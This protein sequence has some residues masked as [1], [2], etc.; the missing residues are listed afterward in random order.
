M[1]E[2]IFLYS[3]RSVFVLTLLYVPYLL[4]LRK[5]SFFRLNRVVL[6][7]ILLS[8]LVLPILDVHFLSLDKQPVVQAAKEQMVQVGIPVEGYHLLPEFSVQAQHVPVQVSWFHV[9][10]V[11]F[12]FVAMACFCRLVML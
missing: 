7:F 3:V 8:S 1:I 9:V 12:C 11:L 5:E 4:I 2:A 6:L 10:S